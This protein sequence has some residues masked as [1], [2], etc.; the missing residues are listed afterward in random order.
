[1]ELEGLGGTAVR[2]ENEICNELLCGVLHG[3][4]TRLPEQIGHA[5]LGRADVAKR[6]HRS[7]DSEYRVATNATPD[8]AARS[9]DYEDFE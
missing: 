5:R 9:K 8:L 7:L 4:G 6:S 1:M 2:F 3:W